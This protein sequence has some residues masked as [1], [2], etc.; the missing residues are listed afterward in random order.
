MARF[1]ARAPGRGWARI[2]ARLGAWGSAGTVG[3]VRAAGGSTGTAGTARGNPITGLDAT[4]LSAGDVL[5]PD[6]LF[7][8]KQRLWHFRAELRGTQN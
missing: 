4:D 6:V 3:S 8:M 1:W 7:R 2:W 5:E